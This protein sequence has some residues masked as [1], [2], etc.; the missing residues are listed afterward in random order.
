MPLAI[1]KRITK[2]PYSLTRNSLSD[3]YQEK[4]ANTH[5]PAQSEAII[6]VLSCINGEQ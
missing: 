5:T 3:Y 2:L 1:K 6:Y 4:L